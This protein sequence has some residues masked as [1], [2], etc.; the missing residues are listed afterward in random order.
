LFT[1]RPTEEEDVDMQQT[2]GKRAREP[3]SENEIDRLT[4]ELK[5][6]H[7]RREENMEKIDESRIKYVHSLNGK[8]LSAGVKALGLVMDVNEKRAKIG[9]P[10]GLTGYLSL[11][12]LSDEHNSEA[13]GVVPSISAY[14][15]VGRLVP[16][17]VVEVVREDR[18]LK[19]VDLSL[20][21]SSLN[22][23]QAID[24]AVEG[25]VLY[26]SVRSIEDHGYQIY[27]G[28]KKGVAGFLSFA[29][30][31]GNT[32]DPALKV[33]EMVTTVVKHAKKGSQRNVLTLELQPKQIAES[34][35]AKV[36]KFEQLIP[37]LQ[38]NVSEKYFVQDG[39]VV[40]FLG[41]LEGSIH[42]F[43]MN[44]W[45]KDPAT[46]VGKMTRKD[47]R[48]AKVLFVDP[49]TKHVGL[50]FADRI[51]KRSKDDE[52]QDAYILKNVLG[53]IVDKATVARVDGAGLLLHVPRPDR[54]GNAMKDDEEEENHLIAYARKSV[55]NRNVPEEQQ[56]TQLD[57]KYYVDQET[58]LRVIGYLGVDGVLSVS[59]AQSVIDAS[60]L[61]YGDITPG[62]RLKGKVSKV[63]DHGVVVSLGES[64]SGFIRSAHLG[65]V[66]ISDPASR[67]KVG[68]QV[69][70]KVLDV[71]TSNIKV[72][73]HLTNKRTLVTSE[74]P[75]INSLDSAKPG[76]VSHGV[77]T[78]SDSNKGLFVSFFGNVYGRVQP[79]D[80]LM[81]GVSDPS[82]VYKVGSVVKV[83]VVSVNHQR[84]NLQ[85]SLRTSDSSKNAENTF[86]AEGSLVE[87]KVIGRDAG[88]ITV[89]LDGGQ[90]AS[91]PVLHL[92][93]HIELA[94]EIGESSKFKRGSKVKGALVLSKMD[95]IISLKPSLLSAAKAGTLPSN[96]EDLVTGVT[97][98]G[99][100]SNVNAMGVFVKFL[101]EFSALCP[102]SNIA[103]TFVTDPK[104]FFTVGQSVSAYVA[105]VKPDTQRAIV[106]LKASSI[107][108]TK[109]NHID[110]LS[111]LVSNV[112]GD[113]IAI[114]DRVKGKVTEV[115]K[116][117]IKVDL[118]EGV[119]GFCIK[120]HLRQ[121]EE[122]NVGDEVKV[123]VLDTKISGA[124][125]IDVSLRA[126]LVKHI[127]SGDAIAKTKKKAASST[128]VK[129]VVELVKEDYAILSL[130]DHGSLLLFAPLK[131]VNGSLS[132]LDSLSI[133]SVVKVTVISSKGPEAHERV[134]FGTIIPS[135]SD[136]ARSRARSRGTSVDMSNANS[137][138]LPLATIEVGAK[139]VGRV[140]NINGGWL[141]VNVNGI[142]P[143]G[144]KSEKILKYQ[145][146]VSDISE[147]EGVT[148][149]SVIDNFQIGDTV[150]ATVAELE[151]KTDK[152][153]QEIVNVYL[154]KLAS[155]SVLEEDDIEIGRSYLAYV[156]NVSEDGVHVAVSRKVRGMVYCTQ[157]STDLELL[158]NVFNKGDC[159]A[160]SAGSIVKV[161]AISEREMGYN[162]TMIY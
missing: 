145:L 55:M 146:F 47:L 38:F 154:T 69:D 51:V 65:D 85:L 62:Q 157:V 98:S 112:V 61:S 126:T 160:F 76:M 39:V 43:H 102:R 45:K 128:R 109:Q 80:L 75:V 129:A 94:K 153:G 104:K 89:K 73:V 83:K 15:N 117:G 132:G 122:Y 148:T 41:F 152:K 91:L 77:V 70:T 59:L 21:V 162:F 125:M 81:L 99:Y 84:G 106:A 44:S 48:P 123:R 97:L 14:L 23:K 54:G 30:G 16:C 139:V 114:G 66:L 25:S 151:E 144:D 124:G 2:A 137:K 18:K 105:E 50:S 63:L 121:G 90:V 78:S 6:K 87:G 67:F 71:D 110:Y 40:S 24:D 19:R 141:N 88:R 143:E 26:G 64:I 140:F 134:L 82:E 93:D 13:E 118:G 92:A 3:Q 35:S 10:G 142:R 161:R 158:N 119:T 56:V 115:T 31:G 5:R 28:S 147:K 133:E 22:S 86:P 17:A 116:I 68:Q 96:F 8:T 12:N 138:D 29:S 149:E 7:K 1:V 49:E 32:D 53:N 34:K 4:E 79:S 159:S 101:G 108:L 57:Q 37:G 33:G 127:A 156:E 120:D 72:N 42:H 27:V 100:V 36:N 60:V 103:D 20:A 9:L 150:E 58:R 131:C 11:E 155:L 113:S 136:Q 95:G 111:P 135:A 107:D 46:N 52:K 130:P 74:L